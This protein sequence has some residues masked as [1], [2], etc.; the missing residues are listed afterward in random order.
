MDQTGKVRCIAIFACVVLAS[1][2]IG[3]AQPGKGVDLDGSWLFD[4]EATEK[5][6][7]ELRAKPL[8]S[9]F[10]WISLS[11]STGLIVQPDLLLVKKLG[12]EA[13]MQLPRTG[14]EAHDRRYSEK[15][16]IRGMLVRA[17]GSRLLVEHEGFADIPPLLWTRVP[18]EALGTERTKEQL[19]KCRATL[20]RTDER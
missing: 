1:V 7:A 10:H 8:H 11:C 15:G 13:P 12:P 3:C 18:A 4:A 2:G 6:S 19:D 20:L 17:H 9:V 5:L 14:G 16:K